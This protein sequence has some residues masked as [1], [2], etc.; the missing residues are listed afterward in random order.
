MDREIVESSPPGYQVK[1]YSVSIAELPRW[2]IWLS[3]ILMVIPI[4]IYILAYGWSAVWGPASLLAIFAATIILVIV[5]ELVHA[6]G[7]KFASG[8]SWSRFRFGILWQGLAPYCHAIDPMPLNAYRFGA[9]LPLVITGIL[10]WLVGLF[11][12]DA[13]LA[14]AGAVLISGAVGD[15]YV[16]W[17][18]RAV[19]ANV[20]VQ[21][22]DSRVGC[23]VYEPDSPNPINGN[24]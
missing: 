24:S 17:T 19:P 9:V 11:A 20:L 3:I 7:W 2:V 8:L 18:L 5:H 23:I 13:A 15:I 12:V 22:H 16:L 21:D 6:I 14:I 4:L 1:D 10:P